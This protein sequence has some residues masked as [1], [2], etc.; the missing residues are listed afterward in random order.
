VRV[1]RL[2]LCRC[3]RHG[4][5]FS[6]CDRLWLQRFQQIGPENVAG[7]AE[8]LSWILNDMGARTCGPVPLARSATTSHVVVHAAIQATSVDEYIQGW[9]TEVSK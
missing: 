3:G 6:R 2:G 4:P 9:F 1:A 5:F 7:R 8:P